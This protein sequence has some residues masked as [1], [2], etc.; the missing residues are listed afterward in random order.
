[1]KQINLEQRVLSGSFFTDTFLRSMIYKDC[2]PISG[3]DS[4]I[5]NKYWLLLVRDN[6]IIN[7]SYLDF[8]LYEKQKGYG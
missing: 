6:R 7:I 8:G 1:M 4:L 3:Q 5:T 2:K